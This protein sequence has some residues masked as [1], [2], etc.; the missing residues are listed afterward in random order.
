MH[1]QTLIILAV[2]ALGA[3]ARFEDQAGAYDWYKQHI[4]IVSS[5]Q[6]HPSKP[7]VCVTTEQSVVGCLNLRDGSVAW[8]KQLQ[9]AGAAPSVVYV[10]SAAALLTASGDY[11]R[12]FDLEGGLKWQRKLPVQAATVVA[13]VQGK[14]SEKSNG[15]ILAVQAGAVQV[16][17][18][19]DA[20]QLSRPH[21]LKGLARDVVVVATGYLVAYNAGS[22]SV[23]LVSTSR[24][25]AGDS[26]AEVVVEAPQD[27]SGV[28]AGGPAG[29]AALSADGSALCALR[30]GGAGGDAA[31]S[32]QRLDALVPELSAGPAAGHKLIPTSAGFVLQGGDA[33][34]AVL[35]VSDG[36]PKLLRFYAAAT[37]AS[38]EASVGNNAAVGLVEGPAGDKLRLLVV[39]A[40]SGE[41]LQEEDFPAAA[42][43]R[44]AHGASLQP[45]MVALGAFRKKDKSWGVRALV[46]FRGGLTALLQQGVVV[47]SRDESLATIRQTLFVDLPA[48]GTALKGDAAAKADMNTRIR[49]QVL[50]AKVQLKLNTPAEAAELLELRGLLSDKNTPTRDVNGFRKLLLALTG[51][52][53]LVALHNGDGR[54][55]WSRTFAAD[56]MPTRLLQWRSYHDITH[57]PEVLLLREAHPGAYVAAINAH[58]GEELWQQP[59]THGVSRVVSVPAPLI[60][61]SAVQSVYLL[62]DHSPA[63]GAVPAVNLLPDS[64]ASQ[65]HFASSQ[66][67]P[68]LFWE[69]VQPGTLQGF[70]LEAGPAGAGDAGIT[71]RLAWQVALPDTV[72]AFATR[73]PTEPIQSSVKVLSDRTIKYKYLNPN[74]LFVATGLANGA[75]L[76]GDDSTAVIA[77]LVDT[78]TGRVLYSQSHPGARGPV[79]AV[80][81]ENLVLYHFRDVESGRFVACSMELY[82]ATPGRDF[83]V[84]DYLFNPNSTQPVSSLTPTPIEVVS[85]SYFS[86]IV[87]TGLAVTRTEQGITAKQMLVITNTDQVYALDRRWVDPRRPKKQKLTQDEMED[88]LT[89]YQDTLPF[90]PLSFATLDK[91]VLGLSGLAV[92]PTRLESTCLLFVHGVDLFYTR[93]A[94]AKGFDSLE[95]DF[96]YALL[97]A[98]LVALSVGAVVMNY[99][100]KQA[101]LAWKWK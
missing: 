47:W 83:S 82:D 45:R 34:A 48:N 63:P 100:T 40:A 10:G 33:G 23:L 6:F 37:G 84:L 86:R 51:T 44:A 67:S 22:K 91:Q 21:Q 98:A 89:P 56:T 59:L 41:V 7:R 24:F 3:A 11:L 2:F 80:L 97:V 46:V 90:S 26:A 62:V 66:R 35:A 87:P 18:A 1:F 99:M 64:A 73:D 94:P 54:V 27:L 75:A 9:S 8:R 28:A 58:T 85:Q 32:C 101:Q 20:S 13:E 5:A 88:G 95:D 61:G 30:L 50:G 43:R 78:V 12:A 76:D 65:A 68:Y 96:N 31:F 93:L 17:D 57:A 15:A 25:V 36:Q 72:L 60:E 81:S 16:L 14:E 19:A 70:S 52:G 79:T 49:Y 77:H 69:G 42:L 39:S 38:A 92:E 74:L 4:G 53:S 29:F 55:M 71:A